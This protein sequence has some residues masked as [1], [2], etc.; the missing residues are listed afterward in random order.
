MWACAQNGTD[1]YHRNPSHNCCPGLKKV[2]GQNNGPQ[3]SYLCLCTGEGG[4]PYSN[5]GHYCTKNGK[6][7]FAN[8]CPGFEQQ[9]IPSENRCICVRPSR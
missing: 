1:P 9:R 3:C 7:C 8:C 5:C 6:H 2:L 4:D